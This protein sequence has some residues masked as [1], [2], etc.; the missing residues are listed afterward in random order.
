MKIYQIQIPTWNHSYF[1]PLL[2]YFITLGLPWP[3]LAFILSM[4]S[5]LLSLGSFRLAWFLRG[6]FIILW[7]FDP[8]FLPFGLRGFF[9]QFTNSFLP[10]LLGFFLLLD[11][12]KMS[13]NRHKLKCTKVFP[14]L[15]FF[16]KS[17]FYEWGIMKNYMLLN[18]HS[19]SVIT[20]VH[21]LIDS[22]I[23]IVKYY[24]L[25]K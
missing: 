23:K 14:L 9:S 21:I 7:V 18:K 2:T 4:G 12:S 19:I 16:W 6:S 11:S 13:I 24:Y 25:D 10:I 17:S 22:K 8:S 5:L 3:I 20:I 1:N 15:E